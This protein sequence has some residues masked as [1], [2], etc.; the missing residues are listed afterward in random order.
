LI[1]DGTL[2]GL[3]PQLKL[4]AL[5]AATGRSS[6]FTT[7]SQSPKGKNIGRGD[8]AASTKISRGV[9]FYRGSPTD[10]R[11]LYAPGGGHALYCVDALTGKLIRSF[12]DNGIVDMHED[13]D[14]S[15]PRKDL[16]N[17]ENVDDFHYSMTSPGIIYKDMIIVGSRLS[18]G[19]L[20]PPGHIRAY[21][22]HTGKRRWIFHTIPHP[23]EPG[24]EATRTERHKWV[25]G[26]NAW[27]GV[28]LDESA[29]S[30]LPAPARPRPI[31]G[32]GTE[33]VVPY[34][35]DSTLAID[36]NTGKLLW[37]FRKSITTSGTG[38]IPP[39]PSSPPSRR[40]ARRSMSPFRRPSRASFSCSIA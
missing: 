13:L 39:R 27:G 23:G 16:L 9:A 24:Y 6:G 10:Q 38:I 15:P 3:N 1:I 22:V 21:D 11:I 25:G 19:P 28:T 33:R 31:S 40:T 7:R 20:T 5:D 34:I 12:G 26:A 30:S 2:Y 18:E 36:A 32:A 14:W 4:F 17:L 8:F 29:A 35:C 37:H